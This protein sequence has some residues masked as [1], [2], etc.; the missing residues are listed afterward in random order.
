MSAWTNLAIW[1]VPHFTSDTA[2]NPDQWLFHDLRHRVW[3]CRMIPAS[4]SKLD[5][6][7]T[8]GNIKLRFGSSS[9]LSKNGT[10]HLHPPGDASPEYAG[11]CSGVASALGEA[12]AVVQGQPY[13]CSYR[14]V[15]DAHDALPK[16]LSQ[17]CQ[18]SF[19]H[20]QLLG[21]LSPRLLRH[22]G[23]APD[24]GSRHHC[25]QKT[26]DSPST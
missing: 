20:D 7:I 11:E 17:D 12:E 22:K 18:Q 21:P 19:L 15:C 10:V 14:Y 13:P 5:S 2:A 24:H 8:A 25:P 1:G 23:G 3:G 4:L 26:M 9:P 16:P 6:T